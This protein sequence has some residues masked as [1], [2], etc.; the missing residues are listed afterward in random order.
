MLDSGG[1]EQK[2][3]P[4]GV[5]P[6]SKAELASGSILAVDW[7]RTQQACMALCRSSQGQ[8]GS[9][10]ADLHHDALDHGRILLVAI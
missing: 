7:A 1:S 2:A 4:A 10:C 9:S 8:V 6:P 3:Q 5:G